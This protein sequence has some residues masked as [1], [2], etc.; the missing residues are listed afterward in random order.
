[1][2]FRV[3]WTPLAEQDLAAVWLNAD[4]RNAVTRAA[5]AIDQLL[6]DDPETRGEPLFDT[7]RTVCLD[8]LGVH[9]EVVDADLIVY[10]LTAWDTTKG[11]PP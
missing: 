11:T 9:F 10:V 8:P 2:R 7:V 3:S 5:T 4:D 6:A 1:M